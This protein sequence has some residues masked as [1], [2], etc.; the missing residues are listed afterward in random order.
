MTFAKAYGYVKYFHP[1]DEASQIDWDNFSIYGASQ[2]DKC[3]TKKDIIN[4]L[5]HLFE[6]IAP[7]IE[8]GVNDVEFDSDF[9]NINPDHSEN[10][11]AT[12]WQHMGL[13]TGMDNKYNIYE[14]RRINRKDGVEGLQL[15]DYEPEVGESIV[16]EIG[17]GIY[18]KVPIVLYCN[19]QS[20]FPRVSDIELEKLKETLENIN[21][22]NPED[23]FLRL[24]N[25]I[26]VYNVFQHFYPYFD[27]VDVNW[28]LELKQ[29]LAQS[30]L[31]KNRTDHLNTLEQFTAKLKD[32]HI[33]VGNGN[34]KNHYVPPISWEWIENKLV[35]TGYIEDIE[36]I[37]EGDVV[38]KI[39]G[40]R[41]EEYFEDV[42]STIS[43][44]TIG[45]MQYRANIKSLQGEWDTKITL[46][47]NGKTTVELGRYCMPSRHDRN[48]YSPA[49]RE[50][51]EGLWYINLDRTEMKDIRKLLPK[52]EQSKAIICDLRGYPNANHEFI[53]NLLPIDDTSK[54]WMQ[55]PHIIYPDHENIIG[56][57]N[58]NWMEQM[59][60][61]SPYL[62]DNNIIF[63]TN[64]QAIS[65][66]ESFMG[67]IEGYQLATIVGQPTAGTNGNVNPFS[68][69]GRYNISW[70]GM[71][72]L[73][74]DGSQHHGIG[75]LPDIYVEKTIQGIKDG[76]D[77]FLEK[78]LEIA[79][80]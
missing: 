72:V 29:A 49:Y 67:Y 53:R 25:I 75:I 23:L 6:P 33:Q 55:V 34:I 9:N 4:T 8:F 15:F 48:N 71:K 28:D 50:L 3:R 36:P 80:N 52:L 62:G 26:N 59:K 35:I 47:I 70:T 46:E 20:T 42:Y 19:N 66:A 45:W 41:P 1:S 64:G 37:Y 27:V 79:R 32:G 38:T 16:K 12:Y 60:P 11:Q 78:A 69:P 77:E 43:A 10:F 40:F 74:H 30:F 18:C 24:G 65:Y 7:S 2:M 39:N 61:K 5:T 63:I 31:D 44:G 73:K 14:S 17:D 56:Y 58:A 54:A 76:R 22:T 21:H 13:S 68:L 57:E 51:E